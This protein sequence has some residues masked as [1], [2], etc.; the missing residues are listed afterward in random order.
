MNNPKKGNQENNQNQKNKIFRN[1]LNQRNEFYTEN[2]KILLKEIKEDTNTWK[3][4]TGSS[5]EDQILLTF[6]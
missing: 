3:G 5:T 6:P 2:Q 4:S 1:K